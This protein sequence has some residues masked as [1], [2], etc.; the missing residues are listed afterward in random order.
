MKYEGPTLFK[1]IVESEYRRIKSVLTRDDTP[2]IIAGEVGKIGINGTVIS[3]EGDAASNSMLDQM[4]ANCRDNFTP[5]NYSAFIKKCREATSDVFHPAH[6]I[7][8]A[9]IYS[10]SLDIILLAPERLEIMHALEPFDDRIK[11]KMG[12][13]NLEQAE[14]LY[15][16]FPV[17]I[18][19]SMFRWDFGDTA[20]NR[21]TRTATYNL[22]PDFDRTR[23]GTF[24]FNKVEE[25]DDKQKRSKKC[26][27]YVYKKSLGIH[28]LEDTAV[29]LC[30]VSVL[31]DVLGPM[32]FQSFISA[33]A[34]HVLGLR[35]AAVG[36]SQFMREMKVLEN[37][38]YRAKV[39]VETLI[40]NKLN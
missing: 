7:P 33:D 35:L 24:S 15:A 20:Y 17:E 12:I 10:P 3:I 18:A 27:L 5:E 13:C 30:A 23:H 21:D 31:K 29:R 16:I 40:T 36:V 37:E 22:K 28:L 6:G 26:E 9:G 8:I 4:H 19:E 2:H 1:D 25:I 32:A 11:Q 39:H 34:A 38:A 14:F